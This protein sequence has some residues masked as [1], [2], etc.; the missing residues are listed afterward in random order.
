MLPCSSGAAAAAPPAQAAAL[1]RCSRKANRQASAALCRATNPDVPEG[2][3]AELPL[4]PGGG[5]CVSVAVVQEQAGR[6]S[7]QPPKPPHGHT[8]TRACKHARP[9]PDPVPSLPPPP[10]PPPPQTLRAP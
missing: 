8:R 9:P 3:P 4:Q 5:T 10:L 1:P 7:Q 2:G 6:A